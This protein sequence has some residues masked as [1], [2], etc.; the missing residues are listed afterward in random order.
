MGQQIEFA[1]QQSFHRVLFMLVSLLPGVLALLLALLLFT[2]L[3]MGLSALARRVLVMAHFD[4]RISA[5]RKSHT[6]ANVADWSLLH[7]PTALISRA[8][9]WICEFV[10]VALGLSAFDS[11]YA[12]DNVSISLLPYFTHITGAILILFAGMLLARFLS[13]TVLISA[14]NAQLQYARFLALG[15][16]WL[17]LV[18]AAAMAV[19]HLQIGGVV[20]ELAFG[21]LFGGIV[22]TLSLA[23]GLGS[24][25]LVSRSIEMSIETP[26]GRAH[27]DPPPTDEASRQP[28]RH[29]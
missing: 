23:V 9:F 18:L 2:L 17:L 13:R 10:G 15:V 19:D 27:T 22:L 11:S 12:H 25:D 24:R 28:L 7:S 26:L 3:G 1:L 14:V 20:V 29:F 4:E 21:I 5:R 16:K 6:P 8:I